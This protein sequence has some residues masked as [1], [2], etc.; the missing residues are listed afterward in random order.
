M[1]F[2]YEIVRLGATWAVVQEAVDDRGIVR[3][4]LRRL[5]AYDINL[6]KAITLIQFLERTGVGFVANHP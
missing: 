4:H 5:L 3:P 1:R 6:V 2:R